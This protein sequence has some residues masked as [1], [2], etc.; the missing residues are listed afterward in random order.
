MP[1]RYG[2]AVHQNRARWVKEVEGRWA[3]LSEAPWRK[4]E[5][6]GDFVSGDHFLAPVK[7]GKIVCVGK[8]YQDHAAEMGGEVP[9]EPLIFLK[10]P[11]AVCGPSDA[12]ERPAASQQVEHEA[13]LGLVIGKWIRDD[14]EAEARAA[15]F[16]LTCVN[17]VTARD[18]QRAEDRFTRAKGFDSF[19]PVGPYIVTGVDPLD[20]EVR[21]SVNGEERQRART[22]AMAFAPYRIILFVNSVMT[23]EPGDLIAT[24]TPAGVGPLA[25]GDSVTV[26]VENVGEL[27]NEVIDRGW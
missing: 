19:C 16:G 2:R 22:S 3:V 20:L 6:T 17:D 26:A 15:L 25:A 27:T 8:N 21:C 5:P 24:G 1:E 23:L 7:P 13:E 14:T 10:P 4:G 12:I 11:T 18:I 9:E